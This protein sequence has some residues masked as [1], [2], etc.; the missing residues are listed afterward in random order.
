M[1]IFHFA[2]KYV[3]DDLSQY[4]TASTFNLSGAEMKLN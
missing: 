4:I 3:S 2:Y 1:K